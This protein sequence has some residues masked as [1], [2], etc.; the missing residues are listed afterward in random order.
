MNVLML[1]VLVGSLEGRAPEPVCDPWIVKVTYVRETAEHGQPSSLVV[2]VHESEQ[3]CS[4]DAATLYAD[5][6]D[7]KGVWL[8]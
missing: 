8:S 1:A 3:L 2:G 4:Q 5:S 7:S 6:V